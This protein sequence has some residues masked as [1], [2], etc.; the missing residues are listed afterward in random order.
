MT[1]MIVVSNGL[2][3]RVGLISSQEAT[4]LPTL[5]LYV[6]VSV[7]IGQLGKI[8][9]AKWTYYRCHLFK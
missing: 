8:R 5:D 1:R 4:L 9:S 7:H 3:K 2:S 6:S